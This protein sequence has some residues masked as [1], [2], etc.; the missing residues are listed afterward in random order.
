MPFF[1]SPKSTTDHVSVVY[2]FLADGYG[3]V[4]RPSL[5]EKKI[6][7]SKSNHSKLNNNENYSL[8]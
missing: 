7:F 8:K 1:V 3:G 5:K 4:Q 6:F 2:C